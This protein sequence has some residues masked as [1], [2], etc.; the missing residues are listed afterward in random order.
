LKENIR[1]Q[2]EKWQQFGGKWNDVK[3]D[4]AGLSAVKGILCSSSKKGKTT[5]GPRTGDFTKKEMLSTVGIN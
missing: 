3:G 2:E 1:S 5:G 4:A